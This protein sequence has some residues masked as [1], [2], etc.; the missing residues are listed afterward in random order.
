[1]PRCAVSEDIKMAQEQVSA[2]LTTRRE[3]QQLTTLSGTRRLRLEDD[4]EAHDEAT[5]DGDEDEDE[6]DN[7]DCWPLH[8][9]CL[10]S[11]S[12][13]TSFFITL[14]CSPFCSLATFGRQLTCSLTFKKASADIFT[15]VHDFICP[16]VRSGNYGT[17][18][19]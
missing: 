18:K 5:S 3:H 14:H 17:L 15:R 6:D 4:N 9:M 12:L 1:M 10:E 11:L 8:T 2:T 7:D 13:F 19:C 16:L